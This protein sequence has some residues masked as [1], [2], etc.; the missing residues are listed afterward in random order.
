[1][2]EAAWTLATISGAIKMAQFQKFKTKASVI[3]TRSPQAER[4]AVAMGGCAIFKVLKAARCDL[5]AIESGL[6]YKVGGGNRPEFDKA[7][8]AAA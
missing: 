5:E 7:M 2:H 1:V 6:G 3:A 8:D 4:S